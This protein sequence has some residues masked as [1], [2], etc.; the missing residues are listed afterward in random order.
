MLCSIPEITIGEGIVDNYTI[1][2][3]KVKYI[4]CSFLI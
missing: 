4:I 2:E 1:L 3:H